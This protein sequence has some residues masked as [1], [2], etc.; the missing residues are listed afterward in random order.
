MELITDKDVK[1]FD[2][3]A[4]HRGD[5]IR[6]HR[7]GENHFRN[8]FV[9]KTEERAITVLYCNRQNNQTSFFDLKSLDVAVGVW[10]IWWTTDFITINHEN[11]S[12]F[13]GGESA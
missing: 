11:N 5:C 7:N 8:G 9:T 12:N 2:L 6:F 1:V 3:S 13:N 4:I 10:E